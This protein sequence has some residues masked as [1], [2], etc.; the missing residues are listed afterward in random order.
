MTRGETTGDLPGDLELLFPLHA[1]HPVLGG[2]LCPSEASLDPPK[3]FAAFGDFIFDF[4][5]GE[6]SHF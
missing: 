4:L 6:A 1:S 2:E 3:V 5:K